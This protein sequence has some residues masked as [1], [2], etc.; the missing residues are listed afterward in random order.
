MDPNATTQN[1]KDPSVSSLHSGQFKLLPLEGIDSKP[2]RCHSNQVH[3][4]PSASSDL[5]VRG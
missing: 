1:H 3:P 2:L 5:S 4:Q